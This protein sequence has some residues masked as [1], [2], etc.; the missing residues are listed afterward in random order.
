MKFATLMTFA[1]LIAFSAPAFASN[2][3]VANDS[4]VVGGGGNS[5]PIYNGV[6]AGGTVNAPSSATAEVKNTFA[7]VVAPVNI[8]SGG[9]GGAGGKGGEATAASGSEAKASIENSGSPVT[10]TQKKPAAN[11]T[12]APGLVGTFDCLGS[13]SGG[14]GL[15]GVTV[16]GGGT[17]VNDDCVNVFLSR[18]LERKGDSEGSWGVLCESEK[19]ARRSPKC[20]AVAESRGVVAEQPVVTGSSIKPESSSRKN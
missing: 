5:G 1:A 17:E 19:V 12:F 18:E 4:V 13:K 6:G 10:I 11:G 14:V 8:A 15:Y 7:P 3:I 20:K 16:S 2:D 9:N